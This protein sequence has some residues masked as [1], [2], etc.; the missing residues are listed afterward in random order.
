MDLFQ[1]YS[2]PKPFPRD[3]YLRLPG[4]SP[5]G[6]YLILGQKGTGILL[7]VAIISLDDVQPYYDISNVKDL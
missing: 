1:E 3:M 7:A 4:G 2:H 6:A 5:D